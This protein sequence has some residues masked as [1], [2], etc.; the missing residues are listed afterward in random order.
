MALA[1]RTVRLSP[2]AAAIV[3]AWVHL[4]C[5]EHEFIFASEQAWDE[6]KAVFP[7]W[8]FDEQLKVDPDFFQELT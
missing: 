3:A 2:E 7:K 8:L 5:A 4:P 6:L 1:G